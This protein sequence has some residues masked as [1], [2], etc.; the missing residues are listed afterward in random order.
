MVC[1]WDHDIKST[2][3][4]CDRKIFKVRT[5]KSNLQYRFSQVGDS[6]LFTGCISKNVH[7]SKDLHD[8]MI[9]R[10]SFHGVEPIAMLINEKFFLPKV[11]SQ[12]PPAPIRPSDVSEASNPVIIAGYGHFGNTVG[13]FLR[14]NHIPTTVL[15]V[16]SDNVDMLRKMGFHVYYGDASRHDLLEIA[17]ARRPTGDHAI[18][19][20]KKRLEMIETVKKHFLI[21]KCL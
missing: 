8:T 19:D 11:C 15:D 3:S 12:E 17:G 5:H 21:C 6:H 14:A 4:L 9:R 18:G 13:R 7:P 10:S 1:A 20:E 16:D 2:N